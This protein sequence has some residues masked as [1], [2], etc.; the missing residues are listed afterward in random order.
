MLPKTGVP[1]TGKSSGIGRLA[2]FMKKACVRETLPQ[3]KT[4]KKEC[5][6]RLWLL[7]GSIVLFFFIGELAVR[8]L[9]PG[10]SSGSKS[11]AQGI[12]CKPDTLVGWIGIP[13]ASGTIK[14][15]SAAKDMEMMA[16]DMNGEGFFDDPHPIK[17]PKGIKRILFLGDSFTAGL[18]L[19]RP[20]RFTDVIKERLG[21][22]CDV[23]NM[24]L[25]GYSTDQ[26]LLV[27]EE[28]GLSYSPDI[29]V[30]AMFM[31]DLFNNHLFSVN[32]GLYVK[33]KFSLAPNDDLELSRI[34]VMNNRSISAL[35]NL[36]TNRFYKLLNRLEL[37]DEFNKRGWFSIF[38]KKY[39]VNDRYYLSL[40]LVGKIVSL[41]KNNKAAFLLVVIPWKDQIHKERIYQNDRG[42]AGIPPERLDLAL[43]QRVV[44]VF[45]RHAGIPVLDL[46]PVFQQQSLSEKL[47][48]EKDLHWT[49][50]GH[51]LAAEK[52]LDQLKQLEYL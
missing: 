25:W 49:K 16:V 7:C 8:L 51:R 17:K 30:L 15:T 26:Q 24:G 36:V 29:V 21:S 19:A 6:H 52:I 45:C 40:H 42:Y 18:G 37:G 44:S 12:F 13:N 23:M 9:F 14:P 48:F 20:H 5:L 28:K 3:E 46:L 11:F 31:D 22:H 1:N 27:L 41:A 34:P 4:S 39:L 32:D 2:R 50:A 35:W 10:A 38:D 47:F 43:P 33:P